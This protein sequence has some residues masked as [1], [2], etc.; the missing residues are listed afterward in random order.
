VDSNLIVFKPG[1]KGYSELAK[2]KVADTETWATPVLAGKR[3]FVRD[4][5]SVTC[6]SID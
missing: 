1:G 2:I 6:W 5:E 3:I 4:H